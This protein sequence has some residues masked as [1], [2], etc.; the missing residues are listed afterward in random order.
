MLSDALLVIDIQNGVVKGEHSVA[1]LA[2]LIDQ[3]NK[4]IKQYTETNKEIIY[5][6]HCDKDLVE[7]SVEW[8]IINEIEK[9][10]EGIYMNKAHANSYVDTDLQHILEVRNI[11]SIEICGAQTEY[12]IDATIKFS[13]G[14]G[15]EVQVG[16]NMTTTLD[17]QSMSAQSTISFY[18]NIWNDRF[19]TVY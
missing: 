4:R 10:D 8:E 19:A 12:C 15:F 2:F 16:K 6:Q 18:E 14:L 7:N 3:V 11:K 1:N 9:N 13:H 5:I 17:N